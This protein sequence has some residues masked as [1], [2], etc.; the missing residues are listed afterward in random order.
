MTLITLMICPA[1]LLID[2]LQSQWCG[3][4]FHRAQKPPQ[5]IQPLHRCEPSGNLREKALGGA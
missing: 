2:Q 4:C 3:F 1:L 5:E